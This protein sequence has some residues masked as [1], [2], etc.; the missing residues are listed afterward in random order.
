LP[1]RSFSPRGSRCLRW[2]GAARIGYNLCVRLS[3]S[4]ARRLATLRIAGKKIRSVFHAT[5]PAALP[6]GAEELTRL[7][8]PRLHADCVYWRNGTRGCYRLFWS[9]AG[10]FD[11]DAR[12]GRVACHLIRRASPT[13]VEEVLRG[14]VCS[15]FLV[16]QG[17]E[18][19]HAGAVLVGGRCV[20]FAAAPG[21]GKSSLIAY[22]VQNGAPFYADDILPFRRARGAVCAWPGLPQLRLAPPSLRA[23]RWRG[24]ILWSTRWKAT[25]AV[26]PAP[27]PVAMSA[28]Y[29][30]ERR[31]GSR[32]VKLETLSPG[33]AFAALVSNTRNF[34]E[35][36]ARRLQTQLQ[37]CSW[38][39]NR[40][41]V[42]RLIYPSGFPH[43]AEVRRAIL[44]DIAP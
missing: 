32:A 9:D 37:V 42:R 30:L 20:A 16:E 43:L 8:F 27:R 36:A 7:S 24:R 34:A 19:L 15:F 33:D 39:A 40:V 26:R 3:R 18:P 5:A 41:P 1:S 35:T 11:L 10:T 4:L 21:A 44:E 12:R 13:T 25:L 14:P 22:L 28:I 38:L 6:A 17:F 2:I 31:A 29:L 23:L